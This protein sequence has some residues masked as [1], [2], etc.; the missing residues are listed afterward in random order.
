MAA[1]IIFDDISFSTLDEAIN[2]ID[3]TDFS[4]LSNAGARYNNLPAATISELRDNL[5]KKDTNNHYEFLIEK[6]N[7][8][9]I[10]DYFHERSFKG[11]DTEKSQFLNLFRVKEFQL[12]NG[13]KIYIENQDT[14]ANTFG[15]C[16]D[17]SFQFII[18]ATKKYPDSTEIICNLLEVNPQDEINPPHFTATFESVIKKAY[19]WSHDFND[20]LFLLEE[21]SIKEL[22]EISEEVRAKL[23]FVY[24][25]DRETSND[26]GRL[27]YRMH[28]MGF[29]EDYLID[30]NMNSLYIIS[31][32]L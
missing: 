1:P 6:Y 14:L 12:V 21:N 9:N 7:D 15:S 32:V 19:K 31:K 8:R 2:K 27:I 5:K 18:T 3:L 25:R 30:Y 4:L 11:V 13:E 28:S 26:T 16:K 20:F 23:L 22:S 10:H 17:E 24:S 29:L